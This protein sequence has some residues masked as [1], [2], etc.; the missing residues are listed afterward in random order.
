M[1]NIELH[2]DQGVVT[3]TLSNPA[4][5]NALGETMRKELAE[6]LELVRRDPQ[7][8]AVVLTGAAGAFCSGGDLSAISTAGQRDGRA[9]MRELQRTWNALAEFDKPVIAAVDGVAYGA[10]FS[11]A[12][13]ADL[14][15]ASD[16]ARFCLSFARIGLVPDLGAL[17]VLPRVVGVQRARE[18]IYSAREIDATEAHALGLVLEVH[19]VEQLMP[20]AQQ[21][22]R[23]MSNCSPTAF[24]MTKQLLGQTYE[25][26]RKALL[27]GEANA[28]ALCFSTDYVKEAA[29]SFLRREPL[30]FQ[31]P[32]LEH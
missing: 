2:V 32:A 11:L 31:W 28:Q 19:T 14:V 4:R 3:I 27:E 9:S 20:R 18:L 29:A 22:A 25:L 5:K 16:R 10:G 30:R 6:A 1:E 17:H 13:A 21:L 8:G 23:A 15:V 7:I 26:D 24:S 12:L